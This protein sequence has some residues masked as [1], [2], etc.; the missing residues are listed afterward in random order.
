[1]G[2]VWNPCGRQ[3]VLGGFVC[4]LRQSNPNWPPAGVPPASASQTLRLQV[5]TAM[6][7]SCVPC[8]LPSAGSGQTIRY[9]ETQLPANCIQTSP[10]QTCWLWIQMVRL[11]NS[12]DLWVILSP[13]FQGYIFLSLR[14]ETIAHR[15]LISFQKLSGL[16]MIYNSFHPMHQEFGLE[17]AEVVFLFYTMPAYLH[18]AASSINGLGW[19]PE[20]SFLTCLQLHHLSMGLTDFCSSWWLHDHRMFLTW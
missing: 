5:C 12:T 18:S 17:P 15:Y 19:R 11:V 2:G 4:S 7:G 13:T 9:P 16:K 20:K 10:G 3:V 6:L 1:M 14:S 8:Y